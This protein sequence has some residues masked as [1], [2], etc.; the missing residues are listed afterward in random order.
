MG[1]RLL[2]T[3]EERC[4]RDTQGSGDLDDRREA[5]VASRAFEERDL[6]AVEATGVAE[7]L[8]GKAAPFAL[9]AEI[10]AHYRENELTES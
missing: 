9:G 5:W 6:G 4:R 2:D 7:R 3:V 1:R 8:L 10:A